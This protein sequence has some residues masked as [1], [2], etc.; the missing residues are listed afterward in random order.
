MSVHDTLEEL[1]ISGIESFNK[2]Y[3]RFGW[4]SEI[5]DINEHK[6]Y[7]D[8]RSLTSDKRSGVNLSELQRALQIVLNNNILIY[9][10]QNTSCKIELTD[11]NDYKWYVDII[12]C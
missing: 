11:V 10:K 5:T 1:L 6:W 8:L 12:S 4:A 9:E 7:I 2:Q 3:R